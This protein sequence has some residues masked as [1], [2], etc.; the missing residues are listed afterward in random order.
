M[1]L[2]SEQIIKNIKHQLLTR[3]IKHLA[4]VFDF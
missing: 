1:F 2:K 4:E 3:Y